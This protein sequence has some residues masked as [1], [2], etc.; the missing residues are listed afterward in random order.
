M[1]DLYYNVARA[2][3]ANALVINILIIAYTSVRFFH[4]L[5][6]GATDDYLGNS[7]N[8][9]NTT[10]STDF[11]THYNNTNTTNHN[12][13]IHRLLRALA[14]TAP[15]VATDDGLGP[16]TGEEL[17]MPDLIED[18]VTVLMGIQVKT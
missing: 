1:T 11:T 14:A 8:T 16:I 7:T 6:N 12:A 2:M 13:T 3:F 5:D 15:I 18:V 4:A 9:T 17:H 10:N